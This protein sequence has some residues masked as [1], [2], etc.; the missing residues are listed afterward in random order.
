MAP[1]NHSA[2]VLVSFVHQKEL[3][4]LSQIS[5]NKSCDA[6]NAS[7]SLLRP[8]LSNAG[9]PIIAQSMTAAKFAI[10][11]KPARAHTKRMVRII[12]YIKNSFIANM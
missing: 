12:F 5:L 1:L 4:R 9:P 2:C 10:Q 3:L 6:V 7:L 8:P 11:L